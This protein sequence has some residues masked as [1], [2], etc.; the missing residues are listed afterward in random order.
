M[1]FV[2]DQQPK[3][4]SEFFAPASRHEIMNFVF[5]AENRILTCLYRKDWPLQCSSQKSQRLTVGSKEGLTNDCPGNTSNFWIVLTVH[6]STLRTSEWPA[7]KVAKSCVPVRSFAAP[8]AKSTSNL[9]LLHKKHFYDK[10]FGTVWILILD[11]I[12]PVLFNNWYRLRVVGFFLLGA[13]WLDHGKSVEVRSRLCTKPG[14]QIKRYVLNIV[15]SAI[16][17]WKNNF[18]VQIIH[19]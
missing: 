2:P 17:T 9:G 12:A 4:P 18:N 16:Y 3:W 11:K 5:N 10:I 14:V 8:F 1:E 19:Q 15:H 6:L 7:M 13:F